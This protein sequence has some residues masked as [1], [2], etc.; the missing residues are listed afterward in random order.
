MEDYV[1]DFH[2]PPLITNDYYKFIWE[3]MQTILYDKL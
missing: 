3:F 2:I 1:Y